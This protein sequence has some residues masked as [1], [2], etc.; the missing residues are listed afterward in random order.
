MAGRMHDLWDDPERRVRE[1]GAGIAR[2]R[3]HFGE[4][5]YVRSLLGLYERLRSP[6]A[7]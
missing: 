6:K 5:R 1:G 7:A 3:E 2:A 4:E